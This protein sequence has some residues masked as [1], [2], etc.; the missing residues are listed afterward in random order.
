MKMT[1]ILHLK[2]NEDTIGSYGI[3]G[4]SASWPL[5]IIPFK[6]K[7]WENKTKQQTPSGLCN[8]TPCFFFFFCL[9]NL[10]TTTKRGANLILLLHKEPLNFS[11]W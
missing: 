2:E 1:L 11:K 3:I 6:F 9:N 4:G 8:I 5:P 7:K 10:C